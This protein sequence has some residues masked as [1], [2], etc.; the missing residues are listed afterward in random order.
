M[1]INKI[2]RVSRQYSIKSVSLSFDFCEAKLFFTHIW[3]CMFCIEN[4]KKYNI[5]SSTSRPINCKQRKF[6]Y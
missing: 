3:R 2:C 6:L 5:F 1:I 4:G